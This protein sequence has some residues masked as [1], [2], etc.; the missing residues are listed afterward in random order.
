[1]VRRVGY[2][3]LNT[4]IAIEGGALDDLKVYLSHVA[5]LDTVR[6][7][8]R[9]V[10][11]SLV[12]FEDNRRLGIGHFLDRAEIAKQPDAKLS[13]LIAQWPGIAL[14]YGTGSRVWITGT[15]KAPPPC[16][17]GAGGRACYESSGWYV[18]DAVEAQLGVKIA[19]Y[20]QVYVDGVLMNHGKPTRPFEANELYSDQIEAI[21]WYA[22]PSETPARYATLNSDC[23]V[24]VVHGRR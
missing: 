12:D 22:G 10:E 18:P 15:R 5:V 11:R 1:M 3:P 8:D 17:P 7:S 14:A 2:G 16:A 24:L 20:A 19:C 13:R 6:V 9:L 23:G 21:E 4:T